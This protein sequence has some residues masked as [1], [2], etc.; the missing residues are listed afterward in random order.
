MGNEE[1]VEIDKKEAFAQLAKTLNKL[2]NKL[3]HT[4]KGTVTHF[5]L[6][7]WILLDN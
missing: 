5:H 4:E 7:T 6:S 2:M 1:G 3:E